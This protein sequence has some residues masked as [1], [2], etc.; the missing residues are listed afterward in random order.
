MFRDDESVFMY[1]IYY[2]Y[3]SLK[4]F[5]LWY[6]VKNWARVQIDVLLMLI[7]YMLTGIVE[8]PFLN[9]C[10]NFMLTATFWSSWSN[11]LATILRHSGTAEL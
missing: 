7:I 4:Y 8:I 6:S 9:K 3:H 11:N 1:L 10:P 2:K 5:Q